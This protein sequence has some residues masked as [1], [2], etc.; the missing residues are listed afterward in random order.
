MANKG[1]VVNAVAKEADVTKKVARAAVNLI[2]NHI[3]D[4]LG[5]GERLTIPGFGTFSVRRRAARTGRNPRT[6][7]KIEIPE[8]DVVRFRAGK[9]L[10]EAVRS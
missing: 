8:K 4:T 6:G 1:D 3:T 7:E 2:V 10:R 5:K 9:G